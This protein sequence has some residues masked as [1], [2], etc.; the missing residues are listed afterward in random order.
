MLIWPLSQQRFIGRGCFCQSQLEDRISPCHD[1]ATRMTQKC[2][3]ER[4]VER[5]YEVAWE[6][7]FQDIVCKTGRGSI[8]V[9]SLLWQAL[10]AIYAY[11]VGQLR[12][13]LRGM[14]ANYRTL[15][16]P[17]QNLVMLLAAWRGILAAFFPLTPPFSTCCTWLYDFHDKIAR[18]PP[19]W[20]VVSRES[21]SDSESS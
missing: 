16:V 17:A 5:K 4:G 1:I 3:R 15:I 18:D 14:F 20:L 21:H 11:F 8:S 10:R 13:N 12:W 9:R 19:F 7:D 2:K 6:D